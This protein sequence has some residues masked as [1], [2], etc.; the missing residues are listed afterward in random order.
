[1]QG[2]NQQVVDLTNP[3]AYV[4]VF[5]CMD[6][7]VTD[8]GIDYIKWD[9]TQYVPVAVSPRKPSSSSADCGSLS[10]FHSMPRCPKNAIAMR[11]CWLVARWVE[12]AGLAPTCSPIISGGTSSDV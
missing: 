7:L 5:G 4:Y 10:R 11:I 3:Q 6:A 9:D 8:L 1:M 12:C 2:R